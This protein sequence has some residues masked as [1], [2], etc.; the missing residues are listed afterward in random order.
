[1]PDAWEVNRSLRHVLF[2]DE[3][4]PRLKATPQVTMDRTTETV[5][6]N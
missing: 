1:M 6:P 2:L 3:C 5:S 4:Y